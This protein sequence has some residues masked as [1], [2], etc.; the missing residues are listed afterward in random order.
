[1]SGSGPRRDRGDALAGPGA[2]W[3]ASVTLTREELCAGD[4]R[5]LRCCPFRHC[6][7]GGR[8]VAVWQAVQRCGWGGPLV[9]GWIFRC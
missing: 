7:L 1:M 6:S 5:K 2:R 4:R 3:G 8:A 9:S